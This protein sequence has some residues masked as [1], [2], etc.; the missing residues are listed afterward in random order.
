MFTSSLRRAGSRSAAALLALVL[1]LGGVT[2]AGPAFADDAPIEEVLV[3]SEDSTVPAGEEGDESGQDGE[4]GEGGESGHG[5]ESGEGDESGD[6][7]E[8]ADDEGSEGF[9]PMS[10][11]APHL[12]G[13]EAPTGESFGT[14][15]TVVPTVSVVPS[16]GVVP[17]E[18]VLVS[19]LGYDPAKVIYV[20]VCEDVPL[21]SVTFAM[22]YGCEGAV[23]VTATPSTE[24]MQQLNADGTFEFEFEVPVE[25]AG[26]VSPAVF[27]IRNHMGPMDRSQDAKQ[28]IS[29]ASSAAATTVT[30][31]ASPSAE[32][33]TGTTVTLSATVAP[34]AAGT[35]TFRKGAAELGVVPVD[36]TTGQAQLIIGSLSAGSHGFT[37]SFAPADPLSF[38]ASSGT[39]TVTATAPPTPAPGSLVWG[40]KSA[41]TDYVINGPAHGSIATSGG[42]SGSTVFTFPQG[43]GGSWSAE[44]QQGTVPFSGAV[45]FT[46]HGGVL[47]LTLSSPAIIVH[48][49]SSATL[50]ING[51]AFASLNL[52]AASKTV[53]S[54]GDVTWAGVPAALTAGGALL[55]NGFYAAGDAL[56]VL[57]FTAGTT[58]SAGAG[59]VTTA[60]P[61]RTP[62]AT[63]PATEG[64][65]ILGDEPP[66]AGEQLTATAEGFEPEEEGIFVVIYSEPQ[67]LATITADADGRVT[68]T[69]TLPDDL[70]G[71][72]TLT[73]QGSVDRG[74]VLDIEA[75]APAV[76]TMS[77]FVG[78]AVDAATLSWGFKEAFRSYIS[79]SIAN[80]EWTVA[81][82]ATYETPAFGWAN[83]T[84]GYDPAIA[85]GEVGFTGSVNFTGHGGVLDTTIANPVIRLVDAGSALLLLDISGDTQAGATVVESAVEFAELDLGAATVSFENGVLTITDAPAMLTADGSAA[86]GTYEPGTE[87]DPVSVT[88]TV[89]QDCAEAAPAPGDDQGE[90][91]AGTEAD[92]SWLAWAIPVALLVVAGIVV[93]IVLARR[94]R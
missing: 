15:S 59:T 89:G 54:G 86:F 38:A 51:A 53:G 35:V 87:L 50:T 84:G 39:L 4:V 68:W 7:E 33:A 69:G 81:D 47:D 56:D 40:I 30:L 22:F 20:A 5:D 17:G 16:A 66:T 79:S 93:G 28:L 78:C 37:A 21:E 88:L 92:L 63:P 44:T 14:L 45:S 43:S 10:D 2:A 13:A 80:G 75:P 61:A 9:A 82:G 83:G 46:G 48:S 12:L 77:A 18:S 19:G 8:G 11:D 58:G 62:A 65:T 91:G 1:A 31:S 29:F 73:F 70:V 3:P 55:F 23:Q 49:A 60:A 90:S 41:F 74:I 25:A 67:L 52:A 32:V 36:A 72:H 26:F 85:S 76:R 42:A 94:K 64:I 71:Q 34:A 57:T 6:A 27:T 24:T